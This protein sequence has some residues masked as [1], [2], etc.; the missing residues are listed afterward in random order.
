VI[1]VPGA[2][3]LD[4]SGLVV[5]AAV[6]GIGIAF[7]S[8]SAARSPLDA[9]SLQI[10]LGD[11]S[12]ALPGSASTARETAIPPRPAVVHLDNADDRILTPVLRSEQRCTVAQGG[13]RHTLD[14]SHGTARARSRIA[15]MN[16]RSAGICARPAS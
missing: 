13:S 6:A 2:L 15:S 4:H 12:P 11:W 8:E 1:D 16:A 9:G 5:K 3:T 7:V 14:H 10:L